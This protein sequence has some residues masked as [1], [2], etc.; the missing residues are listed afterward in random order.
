MSVYAVFRYEVMP[1]R[2]GDFMAKLGEAAS[3]KFDSP[4]M[5]KSVKLL[6]ST[7]PGPDTGGV[8]LMIEYDDMA[9]Y[10]ARTTFENANAEWRALFE[11]QPDSPERLV[12]VELFTEIMPG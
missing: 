10:G 1:G 8:S 2:F 7:V 9:A 6:R 4:V 12:S 11:A 3:A 5:P